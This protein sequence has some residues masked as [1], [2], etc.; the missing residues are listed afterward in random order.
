MLINGICGRVKVAFFKAVLLFHN[1]REGTE[2]NQDVRVFFIFETLR[3]IYT[4][5]VFLLLLLIWFVTPLRL[6]CIRT[7]RIKILYPSSGRHDPEELHHRHHR[8]NL[9]Y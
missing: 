7:F 3:I 9:K 5:E 4:D 2:E 1:L 8:E 6:V